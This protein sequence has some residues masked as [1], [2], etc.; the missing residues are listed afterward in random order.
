LKLSGTENN[1]SN[2]YTGMLSVAENVCEAA[3]SLPFSPN[4]SDHTTRDLIIICY[5]FGI[6][7]FCGVLAFWAFLRQYS[8]YRDITRIFSLDI[9]R[10]FLG[11]GPKRFTY[12]ELKATTNNFSNEVGRGG[13]ETVYSQNITLINIRCQIFGGF[14]EKSNARITQRFIPAEN[15]PLVKD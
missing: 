2:P 3:L 13:L 6:E 12:A 7:L 5:V 10:N 15:T 9:L 8:K 14:K 11:G 4:N 1:F